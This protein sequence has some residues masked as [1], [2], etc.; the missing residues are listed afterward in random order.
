[1]LRKNQDEVGNRSEKQ[2]ISKLLSREENLRMSLVG[3][4]TEDGHKENDDIT[5]DRTLQ[6][7]RAWEP[8]QGYNVGVART[9]YL[10]LDLL[11]VF[12]KELPHI[13]QNGPISKPESPTPNAKDRYTYN[14]NLHMQSP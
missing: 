3:L 1:M 4:W 9:E 11:I 5:V 8:F 10:T 7:H 14:T 2:Q 12:S 6:N 13:S